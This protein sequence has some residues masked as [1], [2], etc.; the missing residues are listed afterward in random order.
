MS[1]PLNSLLAYEPSVV[2]SRRRR[3]VKAA[4]PAIESETLADSDATPPHMPLLSPE[5][6]LALQEHLVEPG[7]GSDLF[8]QILA[9][10]SE[11]SPPSA[12]GNEVD[13]QSAEQC[14]VQSAEQ[15]DVSPAEGAQEQESKAV[16]ERVYDRVIF[17]DVD[18]VLHPASARRCDPVTP[19]GHKGTHQQLC[20][21]RVA[22]FTGPCTHCQDCLS[23]PLYC[24]AHCNSFRN[25]AW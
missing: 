12:P 7:A 1:D 8:A 14:D 25:N 2:H 11:E 15:C 19:M 4:P 21:A 10:A 16:E 13:A 24:A 20:A 5:S 23:F 17:L 6:V 22:C 18:G 3:N 9:A